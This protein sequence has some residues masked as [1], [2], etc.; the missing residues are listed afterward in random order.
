MSLCLCY[1]YMACWVH[2][3]PKWFPMEL[4]DSHDKHGHDILRLFDVSTNFSFTTSEPKRN[5]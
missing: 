2:H 1:V 3:L 4:L 5:Y